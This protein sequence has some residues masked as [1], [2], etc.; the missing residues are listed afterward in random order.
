[1]GKFGQYEV[2][3][4]RQQISQTEAGGAVFSPTSTYIQLS[5]F[6]HPI[7]FASSYQVL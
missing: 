4:E 3:L 7:H 1:M 2:T 6:N 5:Q